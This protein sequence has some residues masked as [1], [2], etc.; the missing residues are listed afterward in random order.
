MRDGYN[1]GI[2]PQTRAAARARTA[3]LVN[4]RT[5]RTGI[6]LFGMFWSIF[7]THFI[8]CL[9]LPWRV[10]EA[11]RPALLLLAGAALLIAF[12]VT[13]QR[14][15]IWSVPVGVLALPISVLPGVGWCWWR[16]SRYR[17]TYRFVFEGRELRELRKELDGAKRIHESSLPPIYP[18]GP[19]R[20]SYVYEPMSQIGGDLIFV[21]PKPPK[22]PYHF[23]RAARAAPLPRHTMVLLDV[24]GHGV[25]AALTVNRLVG[26]LERIFAENHDGHA[27]RGDVGR[28]PLHLPDPGP[29]RRVRHRPG[30]RRRPGRRPRRLR[31]QPPRAAPGRSSA[32]PATRPPSSA[33]PT[34]AASSRWRA[35][36]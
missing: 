14:T 33:A 31:R 36:R 28:Q 15:S 11:V 18:A 29:A 9:F 2:D 22:K 1:A 32:A 23:D 12:D 3:R 8:A 20:L 35:P 24:T 6:G 4:S 13:L 26:E 21:H 19:L 25:A 34:P 17:R 7:I 5:V 16:Y 27:R 10:R 30:R